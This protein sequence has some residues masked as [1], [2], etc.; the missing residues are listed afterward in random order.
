MKQRNPRD[1]N[2]KT[3]TGVR[4]VRNRISYSFLLLSLAFSSNADIGFFE[5]EPNNTPAEF[6]QISGAVT[7]YGNMT[8]GDQDGYIWTV[9]DDDARKRW[10]FELHGIPGALTI[11]QVVRL[12]YADN[13][14]DVVGKTTL[15]KMGTRDGS[16][17][18]IH[19]G[20]IFEPGEYVLGLAQSGSNSGSGG[21]ASE[22][23][24]VHEKPGTMPIPSSQAANS[25]PMKPKKP[26]GTDLT[27]VRN[28]PIAT[29]TYAFRPR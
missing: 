1:F 10:T 19:E 26:F 27:L 24:Q 29:G 7:L 6:N 11:V 5:S 25:P 21:G 15:M 2:L 23:I 4:W 12:E 28:L 9:S 3:F 22:K 17:P 18:S 20:L 8:D 14:V 13:G 16:R